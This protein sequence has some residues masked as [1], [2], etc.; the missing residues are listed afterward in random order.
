[1]NNNNANGNAN[2]P[3]APANG[4]NAI[5]PPVKTEEPGLT[6]KPKPKKTPLNVFRFE[7][8]WNISCLVCC[9]DVKLS[10]NLVVCKIKY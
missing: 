5:M 1:M 3:M 8:E 4:N 10:N 6:E 7:N 9:E 2:T